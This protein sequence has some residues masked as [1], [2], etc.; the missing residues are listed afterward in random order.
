MSK[1]QN[2]ISFRTN[3]KYFKNDTLQPRKISHVPKN[4]R[5]ATLWVEI[6]FTNGRNSSYH[7][8]LKYFREN[9]ERPYKNTLKNKLLLNSRW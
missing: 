1:I 9:I 3:L 7:F 4:L 5:S 2:P 6:R 8:E